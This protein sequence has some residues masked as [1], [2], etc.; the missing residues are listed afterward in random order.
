M[1]DALYGAA[2]TAD[3]FKWIP[4][5]SNGDPHEPRIARLFEM[6]REHTSDS[7]KSGAGCL[8]PQGPHVL[9]MLVQLGDSNQ[10]SWRQTGLQ[11]LADLW[12]LQAG[13]WKTKL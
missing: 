9:A 1:R 6:T 8:A 12:G 13:V 5:W 2:Y 10:T 3:I 11:F 4:M 7:P